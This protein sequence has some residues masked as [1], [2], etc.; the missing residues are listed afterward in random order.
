MFLTQWTR[1]YPKAKSY[2]APGLVHKRPDV[3]F[4]A[5]L[6]DQPEPDWDREIDQLVFRGSFVMEDAVFFHKASRTLILTDLIENFPESHLH[7][8]KLRVARM[9]GIIAPNGRTPLD[10]RLTFLGRRTAKACLAQM[11][12]WQPRNIIVSHGECV[13]GGGTEFLARSFN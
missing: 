1:R 9:A 10:W 7:G 11:L 3:A 4:D 2:A 13:F 12:R 6:G 5:E 8:W